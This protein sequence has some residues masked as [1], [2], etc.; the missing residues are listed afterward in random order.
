MKVSSVQHY[1]KLALMHAVMHQVV[2]GSRHQTQFHRSG[3]VYIARIL[4]LWHHAIG[5]VALN[6]DTIGVCRKQTVR[7]LWSNMY[8][9]SG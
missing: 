3:S 5:A 4:L 2:I 8:E 6:S 7:G 9:E 1:F